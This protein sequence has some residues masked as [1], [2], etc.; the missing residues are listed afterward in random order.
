MLIS[1]L[2]ELRPI[3]RAVF[4][5]RDIEGLSIEEAAEVLDFST[6]AV[7]ARLWRARQQPRRLLSKH[8]SNNKG[9]RPVRIRPPTARGA[10]QFRD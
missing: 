5:L 4:V 10:S 1:G 7:K 6:V 8:F 2:K 3:L 9:Q